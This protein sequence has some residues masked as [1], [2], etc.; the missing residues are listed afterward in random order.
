[1]LT[2]HSLQKQISLYFIPKIGKFS[3]YQISLYFIPKMAEF[4]SYLPAVCHLLFFFKEY[5]LHLL[6]SF[7]VIC[8]VELWEVS[9]FIGHRR[10]SNLNHGYIISSVLPNNQ[11]ELNPFVEDVFTL[12]MALLL[13]IFP[14]T[15]PAIISPS[16][17][18]ESM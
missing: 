2:E 13:L 5:F 9:C 3:S 15:K 1:M 8:E 11:N 12:T 14:G 17:Y 7:W 4:S 16:R 18:K 6:Q 10:E